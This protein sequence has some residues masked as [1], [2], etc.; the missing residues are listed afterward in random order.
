MIKK[1][2]SI[3]VLTF[4][5]VPMAMATTVTVPTTWSNGDDVTAAKLNGINSAFANVINGGLDN[6]NSNTTG[7]YRFYEVKAS[8]PSAGSQG[9][10]VFLTSDNS[11]NLDTGSTW[12]KVQTSGIL[13]P[14]GAVFFMLTGSCPSG[15]TD[16]SA[17]Y[18]NKFLKINA[19]AGTSAGVVLTGTTDSHTLD[20]TEIPA[21]SHHT[22][23]GQAGGGANAGSQAWSS[24]ST[25]YGDDS[26]SVGGGLGHTHT[27]SSATTL[28]PSSV[29]AKLCQVN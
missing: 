18:S 16:V 26:S 24:G 14:T 17:T 8:L 12:A 27:F 23:S 3:L 28:A 1:I 10:T 2:L 21:H 15:S 4:Y 11:M 22:T 20:V 7:G 25:Q 9:R 13:M 6:T 5:L 29:T 19:T